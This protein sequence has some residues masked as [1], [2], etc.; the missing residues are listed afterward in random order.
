[1]L[2]NIKRIGLF[3]IAAQTVM[4]F[5]AGHQYEKYM[6]IIT[7]IVVLLLFITPFSAYK[8]NAAD[9]WQEELERIMKKM[10]SSGNLWTEEMLDTDYGAGKSVIRQLETEIKRKLN[11]EAELEGLEITD[12]NTEWEEEEGR[13]GAV[14]DIRL[15]GIRIRL[16]EKAK[17]GEITPDREKANP[18]AA[19]NPIAIEKIR[20]G[21]QAVTENQKEE[22]AGLTERLQ[23]YRNRFA[24]ILEIEEEKVE[25]VYD[26]RG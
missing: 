12:V 18:V 11:D 10:E 9:A 17:D 8:G 19:E 1:M 26:G 25:V 7:G 2:E 15:A 20:I 5:T 13:S 6:R 16:R 23:E 4:H 24:G 22:S 3:L 14:Q 21:P